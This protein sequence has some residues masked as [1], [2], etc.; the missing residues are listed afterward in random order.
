MNRP[1]L[2]ALFDGIDRPLLAAALLLAVTGIIMIFS[3]THSSEHL[4]SQY[5][6]QT[7]WLGVGLAALYLAAILPPRVLQ[8]IAIPAYAVA[9]LLLIVVLATGVV[10]GSSR[11]IRLGPIG[12]QPSEL[13]KIAVILVLAQFLERNR[14]NLSK[15]R[16][17]LTAFAIIAAPM[18]LILKQPDL[19]TSLVFGA[20]LCGM[21]FWAG[22]SLI[23]LCLI[24]SPVVAILISIMSDFNWIVWACFIAVLF[25]TLYL[26]RPPRWMIVS[27]FVI[28]I[29]VGVSAEPLWNSLH[30]YQRQRVVTFLDPEADA[31]GA[32]YQVIQSQIAIGSGG[33]W[34]QG[35]LE[36]SQTQ[37]SFLPEQHTDFIFAVVGEELGF[38]G[39]LT[40]LGLYFLLVMRGI[41]VAA[42]AK[43]RYHALI[44]G[45]CVSALC[46][47]I[48][49]NIG[50][51]LGLLP[52]AGVP[53]PFLSYG[54][55]FLLTSMILCG[56]LLNMW[57]RRFEY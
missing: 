28:H 41:K 23:E 3:A 39:A 35:L 40:L 17:L 57:R 54:G 13:A 5:A 55:S 11:W 33:L 56:L 38:I 27:L 4:A 29:G 10:K 19:G 22:L 2:S 25:G 36:G 26:V 47:H 32:G 16:V 43:S 8:G 37:H 44:A 50:M 24:V 49:M 21:L 7:A 48:V 52:V 12:F 30:D 6:M 20:I 14:R 18:L 42:G 46:F 45:G 31:L 34:G 51:T 9:L 15:P 1:S 53:L